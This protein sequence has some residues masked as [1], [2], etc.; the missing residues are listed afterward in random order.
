MAAHL[1]LKHQLRAH[2]A[3]VIRDMKNLLHKWDQEA[4]L[5]APEHDVIETLI[6][7][8]TVDCPRLLRHEAW[9]LEPT[10]TIQQSSKFGRRVERRV[11][12]LTLVV[13]YEGERI[14]FFTRPSRYPKTPP[15]VEYLDDSQL[16]L[17]V[18]GEL[19]DGT[20]V[21]KRF[22]QQLNEIERWLGWA[23]EEIDPH[24]AKIRES[25]PSLVSRRRAELLAVRDVQAAVGFPIRKRAD[26]A[27][28]SV[29]VKRR[30][31]RPSAGAPASQ[32]ERFVPE[33]VLAEEDHEAA[34]EVLRHSRDALERTPS[35]AAGMDEETI[36]NLLLVGLNAQ[37][38]GTAS[39]EVFNGNGKT[40]ILIRER[41]RNVFIGECKI[42]AGP[43]TVEAALD[44]LLGYLVWRDTKAAL[45][46]FIR[47]KDVSAAIRSAIE[48]VEA[49]PNYKRRGQHDSDERADFVMHARGDRDQEIHL[50][51]LPF[52]LPGDATSRFRR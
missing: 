17:T 8:G 34:L 25:V 6:K 21:R 4:L 30:T 35:L 46:I 47:N 7:L 28:Y 29:P 37:F 40:D 49:H 20:Q 10:E 23:R 38:E 43:K 5:R 16:R 11:S 51:L 52:A 42:W 12:L 50:A 48:T 2:L 9:M 19:T 3:M 14:L 36:R 33:P 45:L 31:L 13:P 18:E 1:F 32:G 41:D 22:D 15:S 44:Q 27:A 39:G 26:A 24:N